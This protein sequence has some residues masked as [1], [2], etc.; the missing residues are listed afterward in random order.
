MG[1]LITIF[2]HSRLH[3]MKLLHSMCNTVQNVYKYVYKFKIE[4]KILVGE[5]ILH[6][7]L[8]TL[9]R[10]H[11]VPQRYDGNATITKV[12]CWRVKKDWLLDI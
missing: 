3:K 10:Y 6:I 8:L 12:K 4:F 1:N 11:L 9:H 2:S 5:T 7:L